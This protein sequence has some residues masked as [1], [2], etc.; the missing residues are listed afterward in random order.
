MSPE[1]I[2]N[3]CPAC[4]VLGRARLIDY[5]LAF[6][7]RS[8]KSGSGVADIVHTRGMAVWGVLY[9]INENELTALDGKEGYG[10][11]YTRIEI[12]VVLQGGVAQRATT[13]T[14]IS[15]EFNEI[16]PSPEYLST[17]I[18]GAQ[19]FGLPEYYITFLESLKTTHQVI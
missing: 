5:R 2:S 4:Q 6:T 10:S 19:S 7:R 3:I 1:V 12:D 18:G 9:E 17:I 15:K 14:V 8:I 13:Y 16:P 11:A